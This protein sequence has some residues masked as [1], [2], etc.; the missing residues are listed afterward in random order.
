[1]SWPAIPKYG[2]G[3]SSMESKARNSFRYCHLSLA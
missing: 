1:V 3:Q 2:C